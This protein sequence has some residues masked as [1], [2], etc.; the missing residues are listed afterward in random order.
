MLN[1]LRATRGCSPV[2][3]CHGLPHAE[4]PH[5]HPCLGGCG[6]MT[7]AG[8]TQACGYCSH[9]ACSDY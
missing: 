5:A 4:C 7:T 3:H 1:L 6:R 9:C 8:E 2:C